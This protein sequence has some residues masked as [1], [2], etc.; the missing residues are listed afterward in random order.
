MSE[1]PLT[2]VKYVQATMAAA[3]VIFIPIGCLGD[4][5]ST[6]TADCTMSSTAALL[7]ASLIRLVWASASARERNGPAT[8]LMMTLPALTPF[9]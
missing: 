3:V 9:T 6:V 5:T 2:L 4:P 1:V 7:A 8:V